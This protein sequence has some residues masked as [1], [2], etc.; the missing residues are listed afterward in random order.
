MEAA[1]VDCVI[2]TLNEQSLL[3]RLRKAMLWPNM[4]PE[5]K[6][7]S[8]DKS[9]TRVSMAPICLGVYSVGPRLALKPRVHLAPSSYASVGLLA[10]LEK[11]SRDST[12]A[13]FCGIKSTVELV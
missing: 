2:V 11:A 7:S 5:F 13:C 3:S 12:E 10:L 9:T 4:L 6:S 8:H 1:C